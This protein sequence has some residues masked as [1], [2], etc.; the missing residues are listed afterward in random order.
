MEVDR[1]YRV[2]HDDLEQLGLVLK[3][4]KR[5]PVGMAPVEVAN[6][7]GMLQRVVERVA[8]DPC[9]PAPPLAKV[10]RCCWRAPD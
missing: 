9:R 5:S 6:L 1:E 10:G 2:T 4:L 8:L 7:R 3:A